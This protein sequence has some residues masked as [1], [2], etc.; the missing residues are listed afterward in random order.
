MYVYVCWID[1]LFTFGWELFWMMTFFW[2]GKGEETWKSDVWKLSTETIRETRQFADK[3]LNEKCCASILLSYN[4]FIYRVHF[5]KEDRILPLSAVVTK[6]NL[7]S[8]KIYPISRG[9]KVACNVDIFIHNAN[10]VDD[11]V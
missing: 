1:G 2:E 11:H 7:H 8:V 4:S 3:T 9:K 10:A 6:S 5:R